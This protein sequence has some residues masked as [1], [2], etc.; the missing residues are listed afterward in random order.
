MRRKRTTR[1]ERVPA[2]AAGLTAL[3]LAMGF[4]AAVSPTETRTHTHVYREYRSSRPPVLATPKSGEK[5]IPVVGGRK[6]SYT[7]ASGCGVERWSVKTLTDPG[8]NSVNLTPKD[9]TIAALTAFPTPVGPTDRVAPVETTTYRIK[10]TMDA[11][12][13]EGDS[14]IHLAVHDAAGHTMIVEFPADTCDQ[15]S[16]VAPQIKAARDAFTQFAGPSSSSY[17]PVTGTATIEGVG[18]FDRI[19]GQRGVAPN[20]IELHPATKFSQP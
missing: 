7:P 2:T 19:H 10:V 11:F 4:G 9:S 17:V 8:A 14:D 6:T 20:G 16:L 5:D 15:G 13:A 1:A 3:L 18:F 12:K